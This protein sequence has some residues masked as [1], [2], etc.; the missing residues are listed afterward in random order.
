MT[1][2]DLLIL[3]ATF[4]NFLHADSRNGS[5]VHLPIRGYHVPCQSA[6]AAG[7]SPGAQGAYFLSPA[8]AHVRPR[9]SPG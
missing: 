6:S 7:G 8:C 3:W 5:L 9:A 2:N 1:Y 4:S